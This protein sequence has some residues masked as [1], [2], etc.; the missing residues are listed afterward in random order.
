MLC[1]GKVRKKSF[2]KEK[3]K[4]YKLIYVCKPCIYYDLQSLRELN[5]DDKMKKVL[6]EIEKKEFMVRIAFPVSLRFAPDRRNNLLFHRLMKDHHNSN[7]VVSV[8]RTAL[9]SR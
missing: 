2:R 6:I 7:A 8:G 1:P 9:V 3:C 5:N 4:S